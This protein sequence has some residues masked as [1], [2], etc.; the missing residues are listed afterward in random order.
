MKQFKIITILLFSLLISVSCDKGF[1]D[2]NIDPNNP[3]T[4]PSDLLIPG[5]V[6][7]AQNESYST[8]VGGD[9]G[10]CWSQQFAKV[11]YNDEARYIPRQGVI[12]SLWDRFYAG[13]DLSQVNT[14]V[15]S[16]ANSMY[17][18]AVA[19]GNNNMMGVAL[20][21]QAYGFA[22]L[23]DVY[24]DIPFSEAIKANEGNIAPAYDKQ[25]DVYTGI[26]AMLDDAIAKLGTSGTIDPTNDILYS[27]DASLWKKFASS[28]KFRVLMRE[29]GQVDVSGALQALVNAGNLFQSNADEAKLIYLSADP[30]ANPLYESIVFGT[31]GEWKVNSEIVDRLTA[32]NDPRLPVYAALNDAG[33]YRGK[34]SGFRDVPSDT[35]NY[36][37]V[38]ALGDFYLRPEL[39]GYFISNAQ[40]KFLMAEAAQ[41]NWINLDAGTLFKEAITASLDFNEVPAADASAF[42]A[43]Q[44]LESNNANALKQIATQEWIALYSQGVESWNEW[45][46][47]GYPVLA[48]AAEAAFN[49]IPSRYNYPTTE[50][51]INKANVEA[52]VATQGTDD[53][54]T[55]I[56]WMG[57]NQ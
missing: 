21:L 24:G 15:I 13:T 31:R 23:T 54:K 9:M 40:L 3:V 53:L 28:L 12:T 55:P 42:L 16:D 43:T 11:Q 34:P 48:P 39:P 4:V 46:R 10:A 51:S 56:W 45:R 5:V 37:N 7:S 47:T 26:L 32:D 38:S 50:Y 18:L 33:I 27:G 25:E 36:T 17:N 1:E 20:T 8:F 30:S 35:Y 49:Q 29:S 2:L 6:R 14:G 57:G 44:N 22:F 52:A 19:E 41:H